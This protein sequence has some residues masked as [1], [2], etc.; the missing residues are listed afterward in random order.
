[1]VLG[2]VHLIAVPRQPRAGPG[3]AGAAPD[4]EEPAEGMFRAFLPVLVFIAALLALA[5]GWE[6]LRIPQ[7]GPETLGYCAAAG[8]AVAVVTLR[9]VVR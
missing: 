2:V 5:G 7:H 8:T 3:P 4:S 6:V 1:M 9:T